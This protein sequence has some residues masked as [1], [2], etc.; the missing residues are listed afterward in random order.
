MRCQDPKLG[1]VLPV[2]LKLA[3]IYGAFRQLELVALSMALAVRR[4]VLEAIDRYI[5]PNFVKSRLLSSGVIVRG[6]R[7]EGVGEM[8]GIVELSAKRVEVQ[9][10]VEFM[11]GYEGRGSVRRIEEVL[12]MREGCV[13]EVVRM[14]RV[15]HGYL[16]KCPRLS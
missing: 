11:L 14:Q 7:I 16:L 13:R 1:S 3:S 4:C 2:F 9:R 8:V 15:V 6:G 12:Y 10:V 5:G